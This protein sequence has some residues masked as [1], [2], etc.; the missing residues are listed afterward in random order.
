MYQC[1]P[2]RNYYSRLVTNAVTNCFDSFNFLYILHLQIKW[3]S[4]EKW[5]RIKGVVFTL[6]LAASGP[7]TIYC[8]EL[9]MTCR[10]DER[11]GGHLSPPAWINNPEIELFSS[12]SRRLKSCNT[13]ASSEYHY[14]AC[15]FSL[16]QQISIVKQQEFRKLEIF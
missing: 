9:S 3:H 14:P 1:N 8:Q 5:V 15:H 2:F 4:L 7:F 12:R 13:Q 6:F 16:V 10:R 11:K